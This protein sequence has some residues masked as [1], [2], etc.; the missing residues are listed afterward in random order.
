MA[1]YRISGVWTDEN[2]VITHYAFHE[3]SFDE[4]M[5]GPATKT[6]KI[7]AIRIV[8]NRFNN[9]LTWIWDYK[10]SFWKDG[11]EV[12]VVDANPKFLRTNHDNKVIDNLSHLIDYRYIFG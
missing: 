11:A 2:N 3:L 7:E 6:S 9:V 8:E 4:T 5:I 10:N 12:H 1:N